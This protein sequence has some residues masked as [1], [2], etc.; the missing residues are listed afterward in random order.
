MHPRE[1]ALL[2]VRPALAKEI[3]RFGGLNPFGLPM[4]RVVLAQNVLEQR[5]GQMRHM[6]HINPDDVTAD[7]EI[8]PERFSSGEM[9]TT[10]YDGQG[11]CLERWF[12]AAAW[13]AVA[14]WEH[15]TSQDG[16]TRMMGEFPRHGGY[17][18]VNDEFHAE[19]P[20]A[21]FWK[22]EI[23]KW[24]RVRTE[25]EQDETVR[26]RQALYRHR[27]H[28][29]QRKAEFLEEVN[30]I[31]RAV[32]DPALATIGRTAQAMRDGLMVGMGSNS[33]LPAG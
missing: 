18:M 7:M 26:L 3:T 12:P 4:W 13:G 14:D 24:T 2:D 21:D 5:F 10:V 20:G 19:L 30:Q 17:Q 28:E 32:V 1:R 6:P 23:L 15:E 33:H 8:E 16:V 27:L 11:Y 31:H 25:M 22:E 29:E 9:W